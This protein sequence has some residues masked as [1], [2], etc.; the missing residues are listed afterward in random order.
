[1]NARRQIAL[2]LA[3][4][5]VGLTLLPASATG[6][7]AVTLLLRVHIVESSV[8]DL[9]AAAIVKEKH[10]TDRVEHINNMF[11]PAG[12]RW[13]VEDIRFD[14]AANTLPFER[15]AKGREGLAPLPALVR[16]RDLIGPKGF[17]LYVIRDLSELGIGGAYRCGADPKRSGV[18]FIAARTAN[19]NVQRLRKW[20]HELGHALALSHA[21]CE[22]EWADNL[23]MSSRCEHAEPR[24]IQLIDRQIQRIAE[25]APNGPAPC[26]TGR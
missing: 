18:A 7:S 16:R 8:F 14:R 5:T 10:I 6:D 9:N 20:A 3:I 15:A 11:A 19:D 22:E 1:V 25:Q 4:V 12:I 26:K 21:P 23:M 2:L 17:D 24:R 13:K